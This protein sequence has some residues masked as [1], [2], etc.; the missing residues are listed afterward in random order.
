MSEDKLF[1][2]ILTPIE[3]HVRVTE[4][5]WKLIVTVKHPIMSGR[6]KQVKEILEHPDEI[7]RSRSDTDVYLFYKLER[8]NRWI[9]AI[10]RRLN[11][12]GFLITTYPTNAIKEGERIWPR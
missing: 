5:Y 12:A 2:E 10:A 6:E 1:F 8:Q 4:S 3:F 9:C 7:R 11:G